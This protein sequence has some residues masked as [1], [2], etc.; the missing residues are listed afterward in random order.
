[1]LASRVAG[2]GVGRI[3]FDPEK[4]DNIT[5]AITRADIRGL[6][7]ANAIRVVPARGTSHGRADAKRAQRKKRGTTAGSKRGRQGARVGKK[8]NHV[9]RV[10]ALRR[11]LKIAKERKEISN[12]EF[13]RLYG[14]VGGNLVRNKAHLRSLIAESASS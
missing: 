2:V 11:L 10:R 5:D 12:A 6:M 9:A 7:T 13:W 4:L 8:E 3:R 14:R 1:M